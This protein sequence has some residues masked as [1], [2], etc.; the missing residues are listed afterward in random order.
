MV[1]TLHDYQLICP[2]YKL[3]TQGATCE[4]CKV[5]KYYQSALNKC[6]DNSTLKGTVAAIE[7][8]ANEIT[9]V[10]E[11][12]V[13]QFITPSKFLRQKLIEWG[14]RSEQITAI[15]N[16]F[17]AETFATPQTGAGQG[18]YILYAG[19]LNPEKGV[20]V[21]AQAAVQAATKLPVIKFKIAGTG[22]QENELKTYITKHQLKNI[23]LLG[24]QTRENTLKLVANARLIILPSI[25]YEN[26]SIALLEAAAMAKAVIASDIG[27]NPEIVIDGQTGWLVQPNNPD[28]LFSKIKAVYNDRELI[29]TLGQNARAKLLKDNNKEDHYQKIMAIYQRLAK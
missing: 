14:K 4:R 26:Y 27:G 28:Q 21:L 7:L 3:F 15:S 25:W 5:H 2:N 24:H 29:K 12:N 17:D 6:I 23:E 22:D 13:D 11:K 18:D 19:R 20:M 9:Q 16:F 1:Q 8:T 10:Y